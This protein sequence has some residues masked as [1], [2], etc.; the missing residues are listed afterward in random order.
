MTAMNTETAQ[1][2]FECPRCQIGM[3][4]PGKATYT[5]M[6][7]RQII[8]VP[9]MTLY[10]CDVCGYFEFD[11]DAVYQIEAMLGPLR[12]Q[13]GDEQRIKPKSAPPAEAPKSQRPKP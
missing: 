9:D 12:P 3:C 1:S 5:R 8:S 2:P 13:S 10:T 11:G 4:Q 7:G 6:F